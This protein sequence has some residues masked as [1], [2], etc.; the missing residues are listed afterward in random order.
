MR[1]G[2]FTASCF[3]H[4]ERAADI[5]AAL[6]INGLLGFKFFSEFFKISQ[7]LTEIYIVIYWGIYEYMS[8]CY[9]Y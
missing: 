2:E 3:R 4:G 5:L 6:G 7:A 8:I 1:R 9:K